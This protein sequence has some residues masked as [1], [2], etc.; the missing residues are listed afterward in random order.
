MVLQNSNNIPSEQ[1]D[2][3]ALSKELDLPT[4]PDD[5]RHTQVRIRVRIPKHYHE[6]PI[7]SQLISQHGVT[8]NIAAALLSAN[9]RDD[10]WFD[11]ELKGTSG[12]IRSALIYINDLDLEVWHDS[13]FQEESW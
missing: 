6:E 4:S 2:T 7:I 8:V 5:N 13:N 1:F 9:A 3:S 11:L 12:Q 10:G